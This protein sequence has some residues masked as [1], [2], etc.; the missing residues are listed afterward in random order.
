M[1]FFVGLLSGTYINAMANAWPQSSWHTV[2]PF[3][4]LSIICFV[5]HCLPSWPHFAMHWMLIHSWMEE[6]EG[7]QILR[8]WEARVW[9][10]GKGNCTRTAVC[11]MEWRRQRRSMKLML[12]MRFKVFCVTLSRILCSK[13]QFTPA[14]QCVNPFFTSSVFRNSFSSINTKLFSTLRNI[15]F[16]DA[17]CKYRFMKHQK[18]VML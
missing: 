15:A 6:S 18:R 4:N 7:N 2:H 1:T 8:R 10:T 14:A 17:Y 12:S 16:C 9:L 5:E 11:S 3:S 13:F